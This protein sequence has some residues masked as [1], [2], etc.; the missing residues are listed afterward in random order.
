M[1]PGHNTYIPPPASSSTQYQQPYTAYIPANP[2]QPAYSPA[3][4]HYHY[5][6][7]TLGNDQFHQ[8]ESITSA[9]TDTSGQHHQKPQQFYQYSEDATSESINQNSPIPP[10]TELPNEDNR[11]SSLSQ[12]EPT[13]CYALFLALLLGVLCGMLSG[14]IAYLLLPFQK[15]LHISG[16]KRL[17]FVW[18]VVVGFYSTILILGIIWALFWK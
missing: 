3:T 2:G 5:P 18:G 11:L 16:R 1:N 10:E 15:S 8:P 12:D 6:Q 4:E 9:V 7:D 14:P 17:C 13:T